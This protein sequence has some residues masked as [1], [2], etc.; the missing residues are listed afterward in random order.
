MTTTAGS[1]RRRR[2]SAEQTRRLLLEAGTELVVQSLAAEEPGGGGP[3]AH[4][5]VQDVVQA[6]SQRHGVPITTGAPHRWVTLCSARACHIAFALTAR[7]VTC[8]PP[9]TESDHG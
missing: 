4:I 3:L 5:R 2:R 7:K 1:D 6:A 9:M 8:V